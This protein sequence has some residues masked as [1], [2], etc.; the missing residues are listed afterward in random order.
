MLT[1]PLPIADGLWQLRLPLPFELDHVNV[2]L[3]ALRHGYMLVDC[4]LGTEES[5]AELTAQLASIGVE[6]HQIRE[7]FL[8]HTHP[9]HVGQ[10]RRLLD[11]TGARLHMHAAELDQLTRIARSAG[12]PLWLDEVLHRAGVPEDLIERIEGSFERIRRNFVE[13]IPHRILT[14]EERIA[15]RAAELELVLTPGHSPGHLCLYDRA[16]RTLLSGDHVLQ[17]ITPNIGWLPE[18][19]ALGEFYLSLDRIAACPADRI[20]PGHGA[21]FTGLDDYVARTKAHHDKRC[22]QIVDA[23]RDTPKTAHALVS[24]LWSRPLAPFHHRFAVFEVLAHLDYLH[25][26]NSLRRD[27]AANVWI[28]SA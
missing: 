12:K 4:G 24:D 22:R 3:I 26:R 9:D 1:P 25:R 16:H 11:L 6:L 21:V 8:T 5:W 14:G 10:A 18:H 7:I 20:L 19:D 17:F 27:L 2:Y 28:W 15:T 13:L 23:L